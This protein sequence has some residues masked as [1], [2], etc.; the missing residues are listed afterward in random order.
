[1]VAHAE[2]EGYFRGVQHGFIDGLE[3]LDLRRIGVV[4]QVTGKE[5]GVQTLVGVL[6][7]LLLQAGI[8]LLAGADSIKAFVAVLQVGDGAEL[9]YDLALVKA[10]VFG[11]AGQQDEQQQNT[12]NNGG[13]SFH[14]DASFLKVK[15]SVHL[16]TADR[17]T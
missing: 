12:H 17:C 4:H 5:D 15:R 11:A 13:Q 14:S 9:Q 16:L 2:D 6:Q 3:L 10:L 7:C 8:G 1:M